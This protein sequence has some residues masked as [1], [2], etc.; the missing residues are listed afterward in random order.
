[1][2]LSGRIRAVLP[3]GERTLKA[4]DC[5]ANCP[6]NADHLFV[7]ETDAEFL[8]ISSRPVFHHYSRSVRDMM[9]LAVAVEQKDGYTADHC[10]RIMNLA[11]RVGDHMHLDHSSMLSLNLGAFL[12]DVGKVR[13]PEEILGKAGPLTPDEWDVMKLHPIYGRFMMEQAKLPYMQVAATIVEQHHE[14]WNGSGY[15]QGVT[16]KEI[17]PMSAIVAVVDSYDAMTTDRP[18][19][20]GRPKADALEEIRSGRG[21][22]YSPDVADAF[23][24]IMEHCDEA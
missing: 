16:S 9:D 5:I 23:C 2:M 3:S 10:Q 4:G 18:Y 17:L 1:M 12:H 13:V 22:L 14:R 7:A 19:R 15:P 21:S 11:M 24:G 8:Y 20:K 6:V